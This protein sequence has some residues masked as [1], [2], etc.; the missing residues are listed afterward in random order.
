[1]EEKILNELKAINVKLEGIDQRFEK[2]DQRF[3]GIDQRFEKIDQRFEKIDQKFEETEERIITTLREELDQ[4][5]HQS[6]TEISNEIKSLCDSISKTEK[7][8][9]EKME[10]KTLRGVEAFR[11]VLVS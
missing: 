6:T 3:E 1:M 11:R 5:I 10:Q 4:R 2:I 8:K 7:E 9:H